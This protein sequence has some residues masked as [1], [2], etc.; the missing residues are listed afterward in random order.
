[1]SDEIKEIDLINDNIIQF[2]PLGNCSDSPPENI[3]HCSDYLAC[4]FCKNFSVVN[5]EDQIH[6]LLDFK[7]ICISQMLEISFKY[8]TET[9]TAIAIRE[10]ENRVDYVLRLLNKSNPELYAL[11]QINYEP[12]QY[13][14]L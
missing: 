2:T 7:N 8:N 11:A 1:M 9:S 12:N 6:K 5:N 13:F 14:S 4:L 3:N 10:F